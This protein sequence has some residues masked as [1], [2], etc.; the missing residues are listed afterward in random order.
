MAGLLFRDLRRLL[1]E[2]KGNAHLRLDE[3]FRCRDLSCN[4]RISEAD[5]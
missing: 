4:K 5:R 1:A 2:R 3:I